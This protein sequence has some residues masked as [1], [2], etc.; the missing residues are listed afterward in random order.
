MGSS[1]PHVY[2]QVDAAKFGSAIGPV[3][4]NI[5]NPIVEVLFAVG[6]FVFA[7]GI[8]EMIIKGDDPEARKKGRYH[9][10]AGALGMFIMLSAW[11]IIRLIASTISGI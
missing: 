5:V 11:G 4:T 6:I 1:I 7:F 2:A 10:L 9:M 8:V 3:I